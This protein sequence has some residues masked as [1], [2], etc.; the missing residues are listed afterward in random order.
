MI[1]RTINI[2]KI[3][4]TLGYK[5]RYSAWLI[6]TLCINWPNA[7]TYYPRENI[8]CAMCGFREG[9]VNI[10]YTRCPN[11]LS[12]FRKLPVT[13]GMEQKTK[14][15]QIE[16]YE[17]TTRIL[18]QMTSRIKRN[19]S[20]IP[21][22][23]CQTFSSHYF[24]FLSCA[25]QTYD[26]YQWAKDFS[27]LKRVY[28]ELP[29]DVQQLPPGADRILSSWVPTSIVVLPHLVNIPRTFRLWSLIEPDDSL[30]PAFGYTDWRKDSIYSSIVFYFVFSLLTPRFAAVLKAAHR[31]ALKGLT[32]YLLCKTNPLPLDAQDK[33]LYKCEYIL[34]LHV[35]LLTISP[36]N[37]NDRSSLKPT[38]YLRPYTQYYSE[39]YSP[40][41]LPWVG[42]G[43]WSQQ[44]PK[45]AVTQQTYSYLHQLQQV[46]ILDLLFH[47]SPVHSTTF[48]LP[49]SVT[50][51][52]ILYAK[53]V[54]QLRRS[55]Y[56]TY[57]TLNNFL[58]PFYSNKIV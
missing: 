35:W 9:D 37:T 30:S 51:P 57:I 44:L 15:A 2:I 45:H 16:L 53:R 39:K 20:R 8:P 46:P 7:Q 17:T 40:H 13:K 5:D 14:Q 38:Y 23:Q 6:D 33:I 28:K 25:K 48:N 1:I 42:T 19:L 41:W 22:S 58:S 11:V 26:Q 12:S 52:T 55:F 54:Y 47:L 43:M 27:E 29:T 34:D 49:P 31:K 24:N 56:D 18:H 3:R 4:K 36:E 21:M 32:T 10:H 50:S